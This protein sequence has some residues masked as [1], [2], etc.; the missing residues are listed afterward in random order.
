VYGSTLLWLHYLD[1]RE[2]RITLPLGR[3]RMTLH[4]NK[5]LIRKRIQGTAEFNPQ[6]CRKPNKKLA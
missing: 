1:G 4:L 3:L 2:K 6:N 5:S